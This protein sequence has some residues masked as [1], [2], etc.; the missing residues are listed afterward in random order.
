M[1]TVYKYA[2]PLDDLVTVELPG[3]A[4]I[5]CV[6]AQRDVPT[7]WALVDTFNSPEPRTFRIAGTG[8]PIEDM[9]TD[10]YIG[11]FQMRGGSL[12]FH[13]FEIIERKP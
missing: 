13:L 11:T 9:H 7:I 8:H 12:V 5:L 1:R 6:Q 3:G 2:L 4:K 10:N